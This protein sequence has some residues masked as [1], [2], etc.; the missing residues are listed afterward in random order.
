[1]FPALRPVAS[2]TNVGVFGLAV[3]GFK[4]TVGGSVPMSGLGMVTGQPGVYVTAQPRGGVGGQLL[5]LPAVFDDQNQFNGFDAAQPVAS[6]DRAGKIVAF[7]GGGATDLAATDN[8]GVWV[9][10]DV[11]PPATV[12]IPTH[13]TLQT[14]QDL[15]SAVHIA[16]L[17][18][19]IVAGY[20]DA[21]YTY[22]V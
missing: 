6:L 4:S 18:Q 22:H 1:A 9:I 5:F 10:E 12:S 15:G 16:T 8:G 3:V 21:Y 20:E 11:S 14:A 7:N 2:G 17:P 19:A 13:G